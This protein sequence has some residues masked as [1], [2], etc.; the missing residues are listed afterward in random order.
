MASF[1]RRLFEATL[2]GGIKYE[3]DVRID[4]TDAWN[5][6]ESETAW[7]DHMEATYGS[8]WKFIS[9]FLQLKNSMPTTNPST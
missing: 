7:E 8:D 5:I 3:V 4:V 2:E 9:S 1:R 6:K